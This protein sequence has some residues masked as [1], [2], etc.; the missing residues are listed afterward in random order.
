MREIRFCCLGVILLCFLSGCSRKPQDIGR[1]LEIAVERGD[2]K[3]VRSLV[4]QGAYVN[5]R[6]DHETAL[7]VAARKGYKDIAEF[8]LANGAHIN[9]A[10]ERG[11]TPL[12]AAALAGQRDMVLLLVSR[13]ANVNVRDSN[14]VTPLQMVVDH[15][16]KDLARLLIDAGADAN[17]T[18]GADPNARS[19]ER[20]PPLHAAARNA[21][22]EEVKRLLA[23]GADINMQNSK[24]CTALHLALEWHR[25]F[26]ELGELHERHADIAKLLIA[27]GI[28]VNMPSDDGGTALQEVVR[29]RQELLAMAKRWKARAASGDTQSKDDDTRLR[30]ALARDLDLTELIIAKGANVNVAVLPEKKTPLH[31][32]AAG[33][34]SQLAELLIAH[35]AR[36]NGVTKFGDTPLHLAIK[37][38]HKDVVQVLI[39]HGANV[40]ALTQEGLTPLDFAY[41][42]APDMVE[43][44]KAAGGE[45]GRTVRRQLRQAK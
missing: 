29:E 28:D 38:H 14:G 3:R 21:D 43:F 19:R 25:Y 30:E 35:S 45:E 7:H 42:V 4:A 41:Q 12:S 24:G 33:G 10:D 1:Q 9:S 37:E 2:L 40:N 18:P 23:D 15:G 11:N 17:T 5:R 8:L 16:W 31:F 26:S 36:V 27:K 20:Y 39:A 32:A 13:G 22:I 34:D 6:T 44:L